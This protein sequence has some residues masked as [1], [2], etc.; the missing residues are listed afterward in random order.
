M[1]DNALQKTINSFY[2]QKDKEIAGW[3]ERYKEVFIDAY[4][5][6]QLSS[7]SAESKIF[8]NQLEALHEY[9]EIEDSVEN[10]RIY[11]FAMI[12][13]IKKLG[14][15]IAVLDSGQM[16]DYSNYKYIYPILEILYDSGTISV[17]NLASQLNVERH[18][19]TNAIKRADKF[20]L[21]IH[22]KSGRNSLYQIN[23][24]GEQVYVAYK[25]GNVL[26]NK[27]DLSRLLQ[28]MLNEIEGQMLEFQPDVNEII[29]NLNLQLGYNAFSSVLLK[30]S[31]LNIYKK[32]NEYKK[33][34]FLRDCPRY[35]IEKEN[36][37]DELWTV[38]N[39]TDFLGEDMYRYHKQ[40]EQRLRYD[41]LRS[42][43]VG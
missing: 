3:A 32:R 37:I 33:A 8:S 21:W 25:N 14:D 34:G 38:Y 15:S 43:E 16:M 20:G 29:R 42:K 28:C 9:F 6:N 24:K 35:N 18:T 19:L 5:N 36:D 4:L 41:S 7:F 26:R 13:T 12:D 1:V 17:G 11:Y 30:K 23:S 39:K 22:T 10:K 27:N 2:F 31:I 40:I